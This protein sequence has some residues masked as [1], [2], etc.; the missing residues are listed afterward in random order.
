MPTVPSM[1][2]AASTLV[3][4]DYYGYLNADIMFEPTL[5]DVLHFCKEEANAGRIAKQVPLTLAIHFLARNSSRVYERKWEYI[6]THFPDLPSIHSFFARFTRNRQSLRNVGS[7][8]VSL[9]TRHV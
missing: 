7:A 3:K 1:F 9:P 8:V 4:A 2:R 6:P 5:F